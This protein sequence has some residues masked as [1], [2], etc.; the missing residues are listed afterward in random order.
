MI[1]RAHPLT[2][3][4]AE[5]LVEASLDRETLPELGI[6]RVGA[7]P[8]PAVEQKT[9]LFLLRIR[10]K[11]TV[12]ARKERLLLAEEAALVALQQGKIVAS[13]EKARLL[14]NTPAAS[15]LAE[16]TRDR[17]IDGAREALDDTLNGP[18]SDFVNERTE[19]LAADHDRLRAAAG[20][21]S[22]VSVEALQPPDVI[23]LFTLLP[24]ET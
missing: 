3:T 10:Y 16:N 7:W 2:S 20:S 4:L 18:I 9:E 22:R 14:L 21:F 23:G 12:H 13:G 8:T 11:L 24:S 15:D 19:E 6:G 5:A 1:S 17:F